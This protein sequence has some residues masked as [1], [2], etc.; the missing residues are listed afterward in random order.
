MRARLRHQGSIARLRWEPHIEMA[1]RSTYARDRTRALIFA[2]IAYSSSNMPAAA[3]EPR[4]PVGPFETDRVKIAAALAKLPSL[5]S[6]LGRER[7]SSTKPE[8]WTIT[9]G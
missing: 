3:D 2:L 1:K 5:S 4:C 9:D 8:A 7:P 6:A